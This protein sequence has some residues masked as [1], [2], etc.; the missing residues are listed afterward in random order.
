MTIVA[1]CVFLPF[2][3]KSIRQIPMLE[4][5]RGGK[6]SMGQASFCREQS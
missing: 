5:T 1:L 6:I 4:G 3:Q 2:L